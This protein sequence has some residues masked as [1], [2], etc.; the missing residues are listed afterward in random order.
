MPFLLPN[1]QCQSTH[2]LTIVDYLTHKKANTAIPFTG[3]LPGMLAA[4]P[5]IY[6]FTAP[7]IQDMLNDLS[8]IILSSAMLLRT[9]YRISASNS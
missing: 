3:S 1:Q 9:N 2:N 5:A 4:A 7:A 8:D 6:S